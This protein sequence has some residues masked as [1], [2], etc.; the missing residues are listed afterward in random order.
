[1][2]TCYGRT[3]GTPSSSVRRDPQGVRAGA[4]PGSSLTAPP[5]APRME[6]SSLENVLEP[7]T[8]APTYVLKDF[9]IARYQG[10]QFVSA[11][12]KA[13]GDRPPAFP[14]TTLTSAPPPGVPL[15]RLP[16]RLHAPHSHGD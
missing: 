15:L 8:Y 13:S 3:H 12:D 14:E 16:Q 7:C 5:T 10:L 1:M 6:P 2:P 9:P 4:R 11:P